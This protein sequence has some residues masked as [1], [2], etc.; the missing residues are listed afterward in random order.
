MKRILACLLAAALLVCAGCGAKSEKPSVSGAP[1][2]AATYYAPITGEQLV[3][4][5]ENARPFAVMINNIVY[6]QP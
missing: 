5:P 4:K 1:S 2:K 6:V 3:S